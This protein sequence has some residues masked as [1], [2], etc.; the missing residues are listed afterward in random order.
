[1]R[2]A[3]ALI[4]GNE[5]LTGKIADANVLVLA[6][7]LRL[8]GVQ[9]K[10]VVMV[11][12]DI[13]VIAQEVRALSSS[14][15]WL[16]T[17]GGVG[18][19]HDDVT[20]DAVALAFGAKVISSAPMEQM[21]RD[22]Y[23]DKLTEGHLLMA[24]IPEGARLA[25][26]AKMPWPT[27]VMK[28]VWVLPGVPEIFQAKLPLIRDELGADQP[29]VSHAVFTTLDEGTLKPMLDSVVA[30]HP[31]IEIGSYPR[32]SG[33]EYRTKLTFDGLDPARVQAARDAFAASLPEGAVVRVE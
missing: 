25:S 24:R 19:T 20:I 10:R 15:D 29:F 31:D 33:L 28:N 9:L 21:L 23:G 4:I 17:S 5:L 30:A 32:W 6:R 26:N 8:L 12:D 11:L 27:V 3:A 7:A 16:F 14:H 13:D 18:P 22:A 2:T 1:M